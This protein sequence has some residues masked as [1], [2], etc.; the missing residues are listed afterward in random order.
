MTDGKI[1]LPFPQPQREATFLERPQRFLARMKLADEIE[2]IAYCANPGAMNGCLISGSQALLWDSAD[3]KRKRRYTWRAVLLNGLWIGT[4]THL[5]NR[6]VESA[7]RLKLVPGLERY[8][9]VT[10]EKLVRKGFRV[11]FCLSGS[12][13]DCLIEVKSANVVENGIARYP[14]SVTPRGVR[15]L[16]LLK[17]Q[18]LNGQ[19]A[20]LIFLVQR[21][22]AQ[23]F[24]VSP[25]S[26]MAYAEAFQEAVAAGVEVLVLAV[27]VS[28]AGFG[29]P[30]ILPYSQDPLIETPRVS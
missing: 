16:Q 14:D 7:L 22:D 6:I 15:H 4:D 24:V 10:R 9:T 1:F 2:E 30:R 12:Q 29:C 28:P 5:S 21:A 26:D 3:P 27:S 18:V 13:G 8:T 20:V 17:H 23:C 11:D 19:R 25:V